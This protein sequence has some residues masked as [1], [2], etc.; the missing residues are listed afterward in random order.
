VRGQ[1]RKCHPVN[2]TIRDGTSGRGKKQCG[3][4]RPTLRGLTTGSVTITAETAQVACVLVCHTCPSWIFVLTELGLTPCLVLLTDP[5]YLDLVQR[6]IGEGCRILI[7][8]LTDTSVYVTSIPDVGLALI[9]GSPT[10]GTISSL[11]GLGIDTIYY[12][13]R[14]RRAVPG[15]ENTTT[16]LIRHGEAGGVTRGRLRLGALTCN[17]ASTVCKLPATAPRDVSTVLSLMQNHYTVRSS[18]RNRH[19][20]NGACLNLG[21]DSQPYYHGGGWLPAGI[22]TATRVLTPGIYAP[23]GT[24]GLRPLTFGEFLGCHDV[25]ESMIRSFGEVPSPVPDATLGMMVAGKCLVAGFKM[26]N[27]GGKTFVDTRRNKWASKDIGDQNI[28]NESTKRLKGNATRGP[29]VADVGGCKSG[30]G[31]RQNG[32]DTQDIYPQKVSDLLLISGDREKVSGERRKIRQKTSEVIKILGPR[33]KVSYETRICQRKASELTKIDS[34]EMRICRETEPLRSTTGKDLGDEVLENL[35]KNENDE[36]NYACNTDD[37]IVIENF[38]PDDTSRTRSL[39]PRA[40]T[41]ITRVFEMMIIGRA[42]FRKITT[43]KIT[44]AIT[45]KT[46]RVFATTKIVGHD[47]ETNSIMTITRVFKM[48][49]IGRTL[50][51]I[52]TTLKITQVV[53]KKTTRVG[54]TIKNLEAHTT[55]IF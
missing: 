37:C 30:G 17:T 10:G 51:S 52:I 54:A 25:P 38:G 48:R 28:G 46:T 24:W 39:T 55:G 50:P 29:G 22:T 41:A 27:G 19:A 35:S 13:R 1:K 42:Y 40:S 4:E 18:P 7:G 44:K 2:K 21:T 26:L 8:S 33:Q 14:L 49:R 53:T 11:E 32:S 43:L 12:T 45:K 47:D 16:P 23:K 31:P 9:D 6:F 5:T 15:W 34:E 20:A 36:G 3:I